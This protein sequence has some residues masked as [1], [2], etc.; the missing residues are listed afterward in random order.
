MKVPLKA[1]IMLHPIKKYR[2]LGIFP[3]ALIIH[4]LLVISDSIWMLNDI[5]NEQSYVKKR[6]RSFLTL[7][8]DDGIKI[9]DPS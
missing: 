6:F 1:E 2:M 4:I 5:N 8:I 9:N 7:L 3:W